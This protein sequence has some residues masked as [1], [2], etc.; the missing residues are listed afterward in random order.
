MSDGGKG[1]ERDLGGAREHARGP[2]LAAGSTEGSSDLRGRCYF[3]KSN[4][5]V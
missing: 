4:L 5:F 3:K 2:R 1:P